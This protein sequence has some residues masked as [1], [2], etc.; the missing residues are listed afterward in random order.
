MELINFEELSEYF[1]IVYNKEYLIEKNLLREKSV[2]ELIDI[3]HENTKY[4]SVKLND[5]L[6]LILYIKYLKKMLEDEIKFSKK[7]E[8]EKEIHLE[9]EKYKL[10]DLTEKY[11]IQKLELENL[12]EKYNTRKME[13]QK[14]KRK[15]FNI[16]LKLETI[17]YI[18]L[19][20]LMNFGL[21][22]FFGY[23]YYI[24]IIE[25]LTNIPNKF[26]G[27]YF[28]ISKY[29]ITNLIFWFSFFLSLLVYL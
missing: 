8:F 16:K 14:L 11:T 24:L 22:L 17:I 3:M 12:Y 27:E 19:F 26:F 20:V 2:D 18:F 23:D 15:F 5:N 6:K 1:N 25:S 28:S 9:L 10:E 21:I 4:S 7:Y 29:L 13:L